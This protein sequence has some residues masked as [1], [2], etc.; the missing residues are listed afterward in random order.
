M[1]RT[2]QQTDSPMDIFIRG[3]GRMGVYWGIGKVMAEIQAL[4]YMSSRPLGLD[5]M[6]E[7]LK[8]SRSNISLNVRSLQDLG[9][10]KK[11]MIQGDRKDYYTAEE[12]VAKVARRLAA[13][14]KKRELDPALDIIKSVMDAKASRGDPGG[15]ANNSISDLDTIDDERLRHLKNLMEQIG[16][17]MDMFIDDGAVGLGQRGTARTQKV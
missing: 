8:T 1:E 17:V 13:V 9:V 2:Q 3:W 12:D 5:E 4:L 14:K 11:V 7:R 16:E 10:V 15:R 6:S